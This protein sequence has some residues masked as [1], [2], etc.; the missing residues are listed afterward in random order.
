MAKRLIP[1]LLSG[2]NPNRSRIKVKEY[3][4]KAFI[5][6]RSLGNITLDNKLSMPARSVQDYKLFLSTDA[7]NILQVLPYFFTNN[8]LKLK[9]NGEIK[10]RYGFFPKKI[11]FDMEDDFM[12]NMVH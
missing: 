6:D 9:M 1:F 12:P 2:E 4:L 11:K 10:I 8:K 7:N 5:S 3:H